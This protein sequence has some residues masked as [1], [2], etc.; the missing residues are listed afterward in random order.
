MF[1]VCLTMLLKKLFSSNI[2]LCFSILIKL[3]QSLPQPQSVDLS[4]FDVVVVL[5]G[6][7]LYAH[8]QPN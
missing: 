2:C 6:L 7:M 1:A 8:C 4:V 3:K 5:C